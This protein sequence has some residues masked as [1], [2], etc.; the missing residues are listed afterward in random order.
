[1]ASTIRWLSA[2][3]IMA[4]PAP[5]SAATAEGAAAPGE[6]TAKTPGRATPRGTGPAP[7]ARHRQDD[8]SAQAPSLGGSS[9]RPTLPCDAAHDHEEDHHEKQKCQQV[10]YFGLVVRTLLG[11]RLPFLG[12]D[13]NGL[14]DVV[15]PATDA[16]REIVGPETRDNG[17][18][19]DELRYGVGECA[20]KAITDLDT[21]LAL[22]R[23]HNQQSPSILVLLTDLPVT[24]EL[25]AIVLNRGC[26]QRLKR[27]YN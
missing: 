22:V 11:T 4:S 8:R 18:F 21:H 20:F 14:D 25:I 1:M 27:N 16:P 12:V 24:P 2:S 9:L 26:L 13:R 19:D 17:I 6:T 7:R 23:R 10:G 3:E 5:R 15:D